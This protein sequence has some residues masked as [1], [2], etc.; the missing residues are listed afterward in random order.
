MKTFRAYGG[1]VTLGR[2]D[3]GWWFEVNRREQWVPP[4]K[5]TFGGKD[6]YIH[7]GGTYAMGDA[8]TL[9]EARRSAV[10]TLSK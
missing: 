7:G 3:G 10:Q 6:F 5:V 1:R 4:R 8:P 2:F 9:R